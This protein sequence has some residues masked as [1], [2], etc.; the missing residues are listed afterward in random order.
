M[1]VVLRGPGVYA[2][3]D[4][5]TNKDL[6]E[7]VDEQGNRVL[8]TSDEWIVKRSGIHERRISLNKGIKE[9]GIL[10]LR[11]LKAK[12]GEDLLDVE[13]I[14]LASNRHREK[15]FPCYASTFAAELG[16]EHCVLSDQGAGCT[17]L[18]YTIRDLYNAIRGGDIRT[19]LAGGGE[20]ITAFT[21]YSD[22]S[23][24]FL[25]GDGFGWYKLEQRDGHEGIVACSLGGTPDVGAKGWPEG[26]LIIRRKMGKKLRK[27]DQGYVAY[28]A[29]DDYLEMNGSEVFKFA[30]RAMAKSIHDAIEKTSYTIPDLDVIIPHGANRRITDNAEERLREKG[31]RGVVYTNLDK[32][33]N[34]SAGS[35]PLAMAQAIQEGAIRE[36]DLVAA[37]AFGA[38]LTYGTVIFRATLK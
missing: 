2:P 3:S 27:A 32:Y 24:C 7:L 29:E 33:G 4:V 21:D 23:T 30:T 6:V 12:L 13:E 18:I 10:A 11:D 5:I 19:A 15:E 37:V 26:N 25:F 16:L 14:R 34:S 22:R 20:H 36:N 17:G 35:I 28:N 31:F 8:D 38:G 1:G 9:M